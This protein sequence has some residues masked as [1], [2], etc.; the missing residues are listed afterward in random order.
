[1]LWH[2]AD[3]DSEAQ[4]PMHHESESGPRPEREPRDEVHI[5]GKKIEPF[6]PFL[7]ALVLSLSRYNDNQ[8]TITYN[9]TK[10]TT[11]P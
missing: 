5:L 11:V 8:P 6:W 2:L 7:D 9:K 1:M 10:D 4:V 3:Q